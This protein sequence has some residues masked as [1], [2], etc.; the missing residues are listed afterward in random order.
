MA[1]RVLLCIMDGW[2]I[3]TNHPE[4]DATKLAN[5]VPVDKLEKEEKLMEI[6]KL[7]G[8]DVLPDDQ[9]LIIEIAKVIR[10][11]FLQQNAFHKDDTFVPLEKQKKMM[12]M[13]LHLNKRARR[14]IAASIPIS[15]I[16]DTGI[17]DKLTRI[18]Y[19][20]PNDNLEMLDD[21]K[22]QIDE[23]LDKLIQDRV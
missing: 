20:V 10:V 15:K 18:K 16:M 14:M 1:Q 12:K 6:M 7:V 8:A 22:R 4:N 2:G 3:S 23:T 9:K 21:Y 13:I 19:D 5:P 17:F 11:G